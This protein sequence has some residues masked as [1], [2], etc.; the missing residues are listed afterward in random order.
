MNIDIQNVATWVIMVLLIA[1][2]AL[3]ILLQITYKRKFLTALF[4]VSCML[5][6][7]GA[8]WVIMVDIYG[9]ILLGLAFLVLVYGRNMYFRIE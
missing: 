5:L 2:P 8:L 3:I 7:V 1:I 6:V 4:V 9:W